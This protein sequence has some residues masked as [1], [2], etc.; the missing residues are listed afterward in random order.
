[1]TLSPPKTSGR[2][3]E[4]FSE[5]RRYVERYPNDYP[6]RFTLGELFLATGQTDLAIA[7]FQ[8]AQKSP[9]VRVAA[10]TGLGRCFKAKKLYDLAV[11]QLT[12][13]KGELPQ[14]DD[15]KKDV[16]YELGTCL[17]LMGKPDAAIAEFKAIYSEDIGYRDVADKIN[18]FYSR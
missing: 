10:L 13:A 12:T 15:A 16:I 18:A 5:A 3:A 9:Q 6:A 7:Q 4:E 17:E 8:Q 11:M 1:M 14:L 2:T